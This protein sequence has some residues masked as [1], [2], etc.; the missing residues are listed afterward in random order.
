MKIKI[1]LYTGEEIIKDCD[2]FEFR[3]N[4]VSNWIKCKKND[5]NEIIHN[6]AVI[7]MVS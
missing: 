7:K 5:K 3:T 1:I 6:I 4:Q 2:S